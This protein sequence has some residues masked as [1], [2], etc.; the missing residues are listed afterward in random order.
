MA[1][2]LII[3]R[4]LQIPD[5]NFLEPIGDAWS[6]NGDL[7]EDDCTFNFSTEGA[8]REIQ[9]DVTSLNASGDYLQSAMT[10]F[11]VAAGPFKSGPVSTRWHFACIAKTSGVGANDVEL[12]NMALQGY[13][14]DGV[15]LGYDGNA[16]MGLIDQED[17]T[18]F[19]VIGADTVNPSTRQYRLRLRLQDSKNGGG[20]IHLIW[21]GVG[22]SHN[23]SSPYTDAISSSYQP[24]FADQSNARMKQLTAAGG[25]APIIDLPD[26]GAHSR[27]WMLN[28]ANLT[29]DDK[30]LIRRAWYWNKGSRS[31]DILA[32]GSTMALNRGTSQPVLVLLNRDTV[33]RA[34]YGDFAG[35][36]VFTQATP[37]WWPDSGGRWSTSLS[38]RERLF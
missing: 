4:G 36:V 22:I 9:I 1:D 30:A 11:G 24:D 15:P 23:A 8:G 17:Y 19:S 16:D 14:D 6:V 35:Q 3:T 31:D 32:D 20:H 33:K 5:N 12:L 18:L 28:L 7:I 29:T 38:L 26:G 25:I 27:Q 10:P 37:G 21:V 34:M 13:D 2:S